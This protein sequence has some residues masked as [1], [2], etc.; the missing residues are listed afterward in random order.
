MSANARNSD[1]ALHGA[2]L[3]P[4]G[5]VI[6]HSVIPARLHLHPANTD[7]APYIARSVRR[8]ASQ[9][10]T[11]GH[12]CGRLGFSALATGAA[13]HIIC[14]TWLRVT[15]RAAASTPQPGW[16]PHICRAYPHSNPPAAATHLTSRTS[17]SR[18]DSMA[19]AAPRTMPHPHPHPQRYEH[20]EAL[21]LSQAATI[22]ALE[23]RVVA[24]E[25]AGVHHGPRNPYPSPHYYTQPYSPCT[26][27]SASASP[28]VGLGIMAPEPPASALPALN[29][30]DYG[31]PP[32]PPRPQRRRIL[33]DPPTPPEALPPMAP[34]PCAPSPPV[35]E[36]LAKYGYEPLS[37]E[38]EPR[39]PVSEMLAKYRYEPLSPEFEPREWRAART[40]AEE[41]RARDAAA[42]I[43]AWTEQVEGGGSATRGGV[44]RRRVKRRRRMGRRGWPL[45][46]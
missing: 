14:R 13:L 28:L 9:Q 38:F 41:M 11:R 34:L 23:A 20:L 36:V 44:Q 46:L 35:S 6:T 43:R 17:S 4:R 21:L 31:A 22:A 12:P 42:Q 24:L 33:H 7:Q 15:A 39:S 2:P 45:P 1:L 16:L 40:G 26:T 32:P 18:V 27:S 30:A 29:H 10:I 25:C 37:P 5:A 19:I 8:G 3:T